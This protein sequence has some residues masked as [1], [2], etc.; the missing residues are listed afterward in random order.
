MLASPSKS[1][2]IKDSSHGKNQEEEKTKKK[3]PGKTRKHSPIVCQT[4][5]LLF[6]FFEY[7]R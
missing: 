1:K 3:K 6:A 2:G 5:L 4:Q 7:K